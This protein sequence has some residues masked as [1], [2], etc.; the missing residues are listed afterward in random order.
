MAEAVKSRRESP[1]AVTLRQRIALLE[2]QN[3]ALKAQLGADTPTDLEMWERFTPE[4]IR[5]AM[6]VR[7]LIA[8]KCDPRRTL[9]WLG[10][11]V[12]GEEMR[13]LAARIIDKPSVRELLNQTI[14][15]DLESL[16]EGVL[17][18]M[19]EIALHGEEGN[20]VRAATQL[21][22]ILPWERSDVA[23]GA[24]TN[25]LTLIQMFADGHT[26]KVRGQAA[27]VLDP[28]K[29]IDAQEFLAYE[30]TVEGVL[31]QDDEEPKALHG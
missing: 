12:H 24:P 18:R 1:R 25:N 14:G 11:D 16:K 23:K 30:P 5:D 7:A 15:D 28:D 29:V 22:K 31:I 6:V 27:E 9:I 17:R 10:F 26:A 20:A 8:E 4:P 13:K 2:E 19:S 3:T 21:S